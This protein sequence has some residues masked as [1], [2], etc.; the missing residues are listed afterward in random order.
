MD[1]SVDESGVRLEELSVE[2]GVGPFVPA[3]A[4]QPT[5]MQIVASNDIIEMIFFFIICSPIDR[6]FSIL[7]YSFKKS[8]QKR[9][10]LFYCVFKKS[11]DKH[12]AEWYNL[13]Q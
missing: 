2:L 3:L 8:N 13:T 12:E 4:P 7:S 1:K 9:N 11:I 10:I 5:A 6:V